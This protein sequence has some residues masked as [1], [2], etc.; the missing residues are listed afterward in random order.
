MRSKAFGTNVD[1][2]IILLIKNAMF[3]RSLSNIVALTVVKRCQLSIFSPEI[4]LIVATSAP[5]WSPTTLYLIPCLILFFM[6]RI[7]NYKINKLN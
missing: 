7:L 1:H 6:K 5:N 3:V 4:R 2:G